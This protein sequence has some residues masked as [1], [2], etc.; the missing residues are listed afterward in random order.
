MKKTLYG[1]TA[2]VALGLAI[3]AAAPASAQAPAQGFSSTNFQFTVG[4][5]ARGFVG[6]VSQHDNIATWT[7]GNNAAPAAGN[8]GT[9]QRFDVQRDWRL[10]ITAAANLSNGLRATA[11]AQLQQLSGPAGGAGQE[12]HLR[13][14]WVALSGAFGDLRIGALDNVAFQMAQGA[15]DAFTA[16]S[17]R[18]GKIYEYT[19]T[20]SVYGRDDSGLGASNNIRL[21]DRSAEKIAY[22]TPRIEGFQLGVNYTPEASKDRNGAL[23]TAA[24]GVYQR[25]YAAA[26]NYV[27]TFSGVGVRASAGYAKWSSADNTVTGG[28]NLPDPSAWGLGLGV[29]YM[30]FDVGGSY[31]KYKDVASGTNRLEAF[32]TAP[33]TNTNRF[34]ADGRGYELGVG[35]TTG[36]VRVSLNYFN[37][38]M[39]NVKNGAVSAPVAIT[40][41]GKDK[42]QT[43]ALN[44][45]YTMGPGV[46]LEASVFNIRSSAPFTA[47]NVRNSQD[48]TG[49]ITGLILS[50]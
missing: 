20:A 7:A 44:G 50:F 23:A 1:T 24:G 11:V 33:A 32:G 28:A 34:L 14:N 6:G 45:S 43:I 48:S 9:T 16:G 30:G 36:P 13:R 39:N 27:N 25:G 3:V 42:L 18:T 41:A 15:M 4:G 21:Y 31:G 12:T 40:N 26:G 47:A 35:Y 2:I 29:S 38:E 17:A 10:D 49:V 19:Q 22:F 8:A 5:L 46:N 37:G